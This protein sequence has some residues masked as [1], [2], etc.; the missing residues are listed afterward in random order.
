MQRFL[1]N[2]SG[3]ESITIQ[4]PNEAFDLGDAFVAPNPICVPSGL[5]AR[6]AVYVVA[7]RR[8][9]TR[10]PTAKPEIMFLMMKN[11]LR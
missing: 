1:S 11:K 5:E 10:A 3:V 7:L 6:E 2:V 9:G 4:Q 8:E